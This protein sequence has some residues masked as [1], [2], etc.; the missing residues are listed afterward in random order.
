MLG[1][2]ADLYHRENPPPPGQYVPTHVTPFNIDDAT[3][4]EVKIKAEVRRLR[5]NRAC[6]H[7]H[8]WEEHLHKWLREAYQTDNSNLPPKPTRYIKLVAIIQFMWY[9]RSIL[10]ELVW[11]VLLLI[12]KGNSDTHGIGLLEVVLNMV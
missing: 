8:L 2:Y 6:G 7:I 3:I 4:T 1:D 10:V 5:R 9:T 12:P 11:F